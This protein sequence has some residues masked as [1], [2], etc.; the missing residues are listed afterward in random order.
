[1]EKNRFIV[2]TNNRSWNPLRADVHERAHFAFG[3][4]TLNE[5][6]WRPDAHKIGIER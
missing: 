1:M 6:Q 3:L 5:G 4:S 2:M